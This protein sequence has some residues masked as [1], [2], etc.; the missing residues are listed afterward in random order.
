MTR[1][2]NAHDSSLELLL[3]TIC[4]TFGGIVFISMLVVTLLNLSSERLDQDV[5][6]AASQLELVRL[7]TQRQAVHDELTRLRRD[8]ENQTSAI[9]A[10]VSEDVLRA[11]REFRR[12]EENVR[13]ALVRK[14]RLVGEG[15]Q[16]Q[17]AINEI[18]QRSEDRAREI[19]AKL[20]ELDSL[21][22]QY[23]QLVQ[24]R[25]KKAAISTVRRSHLIP[26][27]FFL[28]NRRL[29]GPFQV[30]GGAENTT[31]FVKRQEGAATVLDASP[32]GGASLAPDGPIGAEAS[33]RLQEVPSGSC[34]IKLFVWEDSYEVCEVVRQ[35][36][37]RLGLAVTLVPMTADQH[38]VFT[39][40]SSMPNYVQP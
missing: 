26:I 40:G 20:N 17:I 16:A 32:S 13:R 39:S 22:R 29:Y 38:V 19:E 7:E 15:S 37:R 14:S 24:A 27:V 6:S 25:A 9:D 31:D 36:I 2:S 10:L 3:D 4:N 1:Q 30:P 8:A 18:Q 34:S 33:R 11:A 28:K 12:T 5:P 21:K 35:E 23:D